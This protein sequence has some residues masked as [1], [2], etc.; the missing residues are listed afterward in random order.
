MFLLILSTSCSKEPESN[1]ISGNF[2][3]LNQSDLLS[4][5]FDLES[6]TTSRPLDMSQEPN[7]HDFDRMRMKPQFKRD[8]GYIKVKDDESV[9]AY[10]DLAVEPTNKPI[11]VHQI[12]Q[13]PS[14]KKSAY[15]IIENNTAKTYSL[16]N[17]LLFQQEMDMDF[18][19]GLVDM[20]SQSKNG[21]VPS[22]DDS[23]IEIDEGSDLY[24]TYEATN[25]QGIKVV[26]AIDV[27]NN[28]LAYS[29]MYDEEGKPLIRKI[30][31]YA[32]SSINNYPIIERT[33]ELVYSKSFNQNIDMITTT[34]TDFKQ[35]SFNE[36][37]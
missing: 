31:S 10:L 9:Y 3:S 27:Q 16:E 26:I 30:I 22:L 33:I 11:V 18:F 23:F 29:E 37:I 15:T 20:I 17:K 28:R 35:F 14:R 19:T 25:S 34:T 8:K 36:N 24:D 32:Q 1:P 21:F 12:L 13:D 2:K 7:L 5:E 4:L 6:Y